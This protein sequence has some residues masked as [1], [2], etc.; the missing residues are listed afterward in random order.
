MSVPDFWIKR[1]DRLPPIAATLADSAGAVNLT[2]AVVRFHMRLRGAVEL[3]VNGA[4][5]IA[6]AA[7]GTVQYDWGALDTDT[8]GIYE[9]EWEVTFGDARP[10]TFPNWRHLEIVVRDDVD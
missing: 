2:G 3:K 5:T 7:A 4:A 10:M 8:A 1:G 6:N 9:G